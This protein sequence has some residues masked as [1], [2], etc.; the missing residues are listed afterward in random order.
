MEMMTNEA[1]STAIYSQNLAMMQPL[2]IR[3]I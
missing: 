3:T 2:T 1:A